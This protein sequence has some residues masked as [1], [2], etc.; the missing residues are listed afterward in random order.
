MH[1][2]DDD[3]GQVHALWRAGFS[4]SNANNVILRN[5]E[6]L[7]KDGLGQEGAGGLSAVALRCDVYGYHTVLCD[8]IGEK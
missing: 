1:L 8:T 6:D 3:H 4:S 5:I 7:L 2:T